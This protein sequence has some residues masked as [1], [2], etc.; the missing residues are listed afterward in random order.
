VDGGSGNDFLNGEG[1]RDKLYGGAGR[2]VIYAKDGS[3]D[4][5]DGGFGLDTYTADPIDVVADNCET[6]VHPLG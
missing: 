4:V 5:V 1:G 6:E 2:D 3:K